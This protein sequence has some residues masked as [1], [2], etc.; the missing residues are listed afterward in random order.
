LLPSLLCPECCIGLRSSASQYQRC[1]GGNLA[2]SFVTPA[3]SDSIRDLPNP[4]ISFSGPSSDTRAVPVVT[5]LMVLMSHSIYLFGSLW[6]ASPQATLNLPQFARASSHP[7]IRR[8]A[9]NGQTETGCEVVDLKE[10]IVDE[11]G[12]KPIACA[13]AA[14]L[15]RPD[16]VSLWKM[17]STKIVPVYKSI[18]TT[19]TTN[20]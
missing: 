14:T 2:V 6:R 20:V 4:S 5:T 8:D 15:V 12:Q 19:L 10:F 13:L 16:A 7:S 11:T 17:P 9:P 3:D 18:G 1:N